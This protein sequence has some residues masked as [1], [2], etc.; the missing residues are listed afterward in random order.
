MG[1]LYLDTPP[2]TLDVRPAILRPG[3]VVRVAFRVLRIPGALALP[4]FDVSVF[5]RRPSRVA[6]LLR[7]PVRP[8]G[9]VVCLDWDGRDDRGCLLEPGRYQLRV[10]GLGN[11]LLLERTLTI[12]G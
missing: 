4:R 3:D 7:E 5:D 12:E 1:H 11:P 2:P 6:T 9:G 8:T 10:K